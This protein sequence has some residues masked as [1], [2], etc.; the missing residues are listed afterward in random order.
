MRSEFNC[1]YLAKCIGRV[2]TT[3]ETRKLG[4]FTPNKMG[5]PGHPGTLGAHRQWLLA[6]I[7][8]N[9]SCG[10]GRWMII[11]CDTKCNTIGH[12]NMQWCNV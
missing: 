8:H 6:R 4:Q 2:N 10:S 11:L 5:I 12:N 1:I 7:R 9:S 3:A